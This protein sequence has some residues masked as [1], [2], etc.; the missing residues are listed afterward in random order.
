MVECV[1][2]I[3]AE[4]LLL[5]PRFRPGP[6]PFFPSEQNRKWSHLPPMC[7]AFS[8]NR[9]T[10]FSDT[11]WHKGITWNP[12][13]ECSYKEEKECGDT[14][15][16]RNGEHCCCSAWF[17]C[18]CQGRLFSLKRIDTFSLLHNDTNCDLWTHK[19]SLALHCWHIDMS[20]YPQCH[21]YPHA[22][23]MA[24]RASSKIFIAL[25]DNQKCTICQ[26]MSG[27]I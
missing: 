23:S 8:V 1:P 10:V 21:P 24:K 16:C 7:F 26:V 27:N 13:P 6:L 19:C 5:R 11:N 2:C 25:G 15:D 4:S 12:G 17:F 22:A 20:I 9:S 18:P 3:Q 14:M